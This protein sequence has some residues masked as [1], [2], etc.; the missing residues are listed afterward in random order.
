[1]K[2]CIKFSLMGLGS[3][4]LLAA[5]GGTDGYMAADSR[6]HRRIALTVD[7]CLFASGAVPNATV[8]TALARPFSI[9]PG[10]GEVVAHCSA[11]DW[12]RTVRQCVKPDGTPLFIMPSDD[13]ARFSDADLAALVALMRTGKRPDGP[14]VAVM[15]FESLGQM[16]DTDL[17]ALQLYL[18]SL[19]LRAAGAR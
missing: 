14:A 5:A 3:M 10:E 16:N 12:V 13:Y 17:K 8:S 7:C 9:S 11:D 18:Q 4:L 2:P 6:M 15:P 19:A 1:M